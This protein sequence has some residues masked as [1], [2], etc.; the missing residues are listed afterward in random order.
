MRGELRSFFLRMFLGGELLLQAFGLDE[1]VIGV[2]KL[3]LPLEAE[4]VKVTGIVQL[5]IG[6][7][8]QQMG[9]GVSLKVLD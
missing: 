3:A 5:P 2:L 4:A 6:K 7:H 8:F 1:N 9:I